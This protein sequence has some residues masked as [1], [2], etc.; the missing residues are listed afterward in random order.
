VEKPGGDSGQEGLEVD[1]QRF[2]GSL[3]KLEI[4]YTLYFG[5]QRARPPLELRAAV[6]RIITRWERTSIE[7][8]SARF[9]FGTLVQ[10]FRTYATMWDRG[11]RAREEGRTGPFRG[12]G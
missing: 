12:R 9:R 1:L 8:S 7:S 3:R 11:M 2:D 10:R 6:E 5:G 4:E